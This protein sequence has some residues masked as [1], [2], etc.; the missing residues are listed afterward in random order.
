LAAPD[1]L[2]PQ[3]GVVAS[4]RQGSPPK[5]CGGPRRW[6]HDRRATDTRGLV[7]RDRVVG[8]ICSD[9]RPVSMR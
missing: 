6:H 5:H 3:N 4:A 9:A 7:G 1:L 8:S 2:D